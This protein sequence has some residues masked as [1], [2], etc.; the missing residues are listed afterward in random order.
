[1]QLPDEMKLVLMSNQVELEDAKRLADLKVQNDD[2]IALCYR[3]QSAEGA[4]GQLLCLCMSAQA[5]APHTLGT[6]SA[7]PPLCQVSLAAPRRVSASS[8]I[9]LAHA[10]GDPGWEDVNITA[11]PA[12]KAA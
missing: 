11:F 10:D 6:A 12:D 2:I 3:K 8:R 4:S 1:M 5:H 9:T 7:P